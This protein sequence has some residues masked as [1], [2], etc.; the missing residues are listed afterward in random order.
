[1]AES[2][3]TNQKSF[4]PKNRQCSILAPEKLEPFM[5]IE[6]LQSYMESRMPQID[7]HNQQIA[8]NKELLLNGRNFTNLG[9]FRA[10]VE[11]YL[12]EHPQINPNLTLLCRQLA[13][14]HKASRW[15]YTPL[16]PIKIG[17]TTND[18][19][20]YFRSSVGSLAHLSAQMF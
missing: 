15:K 1:M 20:R 18:S 5:K 13:R 9:L 17:G 8:S 3:T 12:S 10:Y 11:A 14:V 4:T 6:R 16:V 7:D 19:F 2:G